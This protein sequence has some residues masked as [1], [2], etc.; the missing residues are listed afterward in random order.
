MKG[1][2]MSRRTLD[3]GGGGCRQA[4]VS[5]PVLEVPDWGTTLQDTKM[6]LKC[7]SMKLY[8]GENMCLNCGNDIIA[9]ESA[10]Q[11][12]KCAGFE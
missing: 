6:I 12:N 1:K 7:R 3:L 8:G 10:E 4:V 5:G 9:G 11:K 2:K